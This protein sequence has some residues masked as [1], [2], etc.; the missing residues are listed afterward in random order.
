MRAIQVKRFGGPEVLEV[1]DLPAPTPQGSL[2]LL[3]VTASGVNYADTHQA[4]DDYLAPQT[5][6]FVPGAEVV[7]VDPDGRRVVALVSSGGY[8]EQT[9]AHPG[10][11]FALPDEVDDTTALAFVLQGTTAWHLLRT[12]ARMA[13]G[14]SVVVHAGAGGVGCLA[15]QLAR[16][17]G[18]RRII[19]TASSPEKRDL[20]RDLG[21]DVALDPGPVTGDS[22]DL[23]DALVEANEGRPVDIVLEM[24]GGRLFESSFRALAPFGRLVTY[25]MASRVDPKPIEARHLMASSRSVVGFWLPHALQLPGGLRPAMEELLDLHAA[26]RLHAVDG[27]RYPLEH[28]RQAHEDIASRRTQGK[29]VLDLA[30]T[31]D[32]LAPPT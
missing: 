22:T 8:A 26:G 2:Q 25:G 27:G 29:L 21:A 15:V 9:L 28:A 30:L 13:P 19:A 11:T 18:A 31:P 1:V 7:G 16:E 20:A 24:A 14:E 12:S 23:R 10:T 5:L 32:P 3:A 17:L 4:A 6:P